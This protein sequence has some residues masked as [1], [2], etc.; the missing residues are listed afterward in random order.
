MK[1]LE[2][3]MRLNLAKGHH[4]CYAEYEYCEVNE[5]RVLVGAGVLMAE[6]QYKPQIERELIGRMRKGCM[7]ERQKQ[8]LPRLKP[9]S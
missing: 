8:E 3:D 5:M 4:G 7:K 1:Q 2:S 9:S 6:V